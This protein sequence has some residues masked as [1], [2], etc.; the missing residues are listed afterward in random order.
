M[1]PKKSVGR[2]PAV[3]GETLTNVTARLS[4]AEIAALDGVRRKRPEL[5]TRSALIREAVHAFLKKEE[6]RG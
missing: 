5:P 3:E 6:L 4:T 1:Q 2:P